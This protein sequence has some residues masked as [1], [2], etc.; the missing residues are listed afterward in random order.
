[1]ILKGNENVELSEKPNITKP[2]RI[3]EPE[4]P[5]YPYVAP[6]RQGAK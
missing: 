2:N 6:D 3:F 4:E 1:M 5:N